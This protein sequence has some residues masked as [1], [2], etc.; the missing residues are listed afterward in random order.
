MQEMFEHQ[1][2]LEKPES[3]ARPG[4]ISVEPLLKAAA[5]Q[6]RL[7]GCTA[8]ANL[9]FGDDGGFRYPVSR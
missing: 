2:S 1:I 9:K 3:K 8:A 4:G 6:A 7:Q 5:L